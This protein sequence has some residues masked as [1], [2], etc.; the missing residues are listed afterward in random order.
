[1]RT[2]SFLAFAL[3][4]ATGCMTDAESPDGADEDGLSAGKADGTELSECEKQ[5]IVDY[6]N[7][8]LS[9][10]ALEEA[11]VHRRAATNLTK[12]RDG[13]DGT[14]GTD[15]DDLFDTA[16]EV[17]GVPYVGPSAFAALHAATASR[18]EVVGDIYEAAR[19]VNKALIVFPEG[20]QA[21]TDY[22][23]PDGGDFDL[24]GTEFWQKWSGGHNPTYSFDEGTD[25]G[26]LCM[27]ASAIRFETIM[28][29]PP[30]E[31]VRLAAET[32]WDGSF[33]N[34]NDDYSGPNAYGDGSSARL[35]AW[36]T[37][38]IK[39]ISQTK[40]DGSCYL[41]T[42]DLLIRAATSCLA[43]GASNGGEIQGCRS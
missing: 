37:Y 33:Y 35:W 3:V 39:W 1:M 31:L 22:D 34:W 6:L 14:F 2:A 27:Q 16:E 40:R 7:E 26:R 25:A 21:P 12:H 9:R 17:D 41:P 20:T 28:K 38:L 10:S 18:C 24:N 8:G 5:A 36:Q 32:N 4:A 30:A 19:D 13:A 42:R 23:Y 15:D 11:G 43:T 29:D